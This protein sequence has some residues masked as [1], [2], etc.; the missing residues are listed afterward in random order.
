M[1][2]EPI[3]DIPQHLPPRKRQELG[4]VLRILFEELDAWRAGKSEQKRSSRIIAVIL[5]GSYS[6]DDWVE[7][8][9]SGYRSDFDILAV[10]SNHQAAVSDELWEAVNDRLSREVFLGS[11]LETPS[12]VIAHSLKD[13]NDKLARGLPFF[14]DIMRDGIRLYEASGYT[15]VSPRALSPK[16]HLTQAA[17]Y[18]QRWLDDASY[19]A[20]Q[21]K[22][23]QNDGMYRHSAFDL[24]QAVE[25]FYHCLLLVL[26]LYSPKSH[27]LKALRSL[28][29]RTDPR[30]T[31]AW[32]RDTRFARRCFERL[33]RA[34]V[35]A[36]YS[37]R[38]EITVAELS[39]LMERVQV[40]HDLVKLVCEEHLAKLRAHMG[41]EE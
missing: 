16:A 12:K 3:P 34:Y 15:F 1:A 27:R 20:T 11:R 38:Y 37:P 33:D 35:E 32:P 6:R 5:F 8:R 9:I 29:E 10:T 36:R 19:C 41:P 25:R 21:A 22:A 30:L 17:E 7:D 4:Y 23:A 2:T 26:T 18:F 39:W 31:H 14:I 28:A 13:L 40:L 24:H